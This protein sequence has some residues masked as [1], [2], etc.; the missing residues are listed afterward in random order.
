M[1]LEI[2]PHAGFC[3][4]VRRA[5]SA[6]EALAE[7]GEPACTLGE[8]IHNP[9]VV[10]MLR[11][12]GIPPV[13]D[14]GEAAGRRVL[15]RSHGVSPAVLQALE[16]AG[17]AVED[18]TCPFVDKLHH[19]AEEASAD[20]SPVIVVGERSHP[21]VAGTVGWIR[22][23]AWVV[24]TPEEAELLP[25]M[26]R[27]TVCSQTTFPP[28]VWDAV[29][30]VLRRK[31]EQLTEKCTICPATEIRQREAREL[32]ARSDAM[33]VVGGRHSANTA[34]LYATC[35]ALC[36]RTILVECAAEIPPAFANTHSE[37][38]GI[39]AGASTPDGLLKE[40]VT[41]MTDNE[42]MNPVAPQEAAE[43]DFAAAID[44]TMVHYRPGAVLTGTVISIG[45]EEVIVNIGGKSDGLIKKSDLVDK[46][47]QPGS[48]IE[49]EVVK[50]NDGEGNVV[51]SQ[52]NIVN[53]KAWEALM[54]KYNAGEYVT[55]VGREAVKGGL[56][57]DV[58]GIRAFVPASQLD[59]RYVEKIASFVGKEMKLKIIEVDEKKKRV[60]ASRRVAI[61][62]EA[63]A[64]KEEAWSRLEE[65]A[66]IHGIVR[67]LTAFGAFVD[68][69][70][71]DGLVHITDLSWAHI[72]DPSE[73]VKPNQEID[74][75]VLKL[76]RERDRIQLGYKQLQ[77]KPWDNAELKYPVG[78]IVAGKAVRITSFGCFVELEPG[79][80]GL[81]HI[82]QCAPTPVAKVE[83]AVTVGEIVHVKVLSVDTENKRISLSIRQALEEE[84]M[85]NLEEEN[86]EL[87]EGGEAPAE[88]APVEEAPAE[89][90]AP[91]APEA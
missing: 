85:D 67:R 12:K 21:E 86:L 42:N 78:S 82:T 64:R 27:A 20:G 41:T 4:G 19:I 59:N 66:V 53:R 52:R 91:E 46:D 88:E 57:A 58:D 77:P 61:Q 65:G 39:T 45:D 71:V 43:S 29:V 25:E 49:V 38:I 75:V 79:L 26:A 24:A 16:A 51:L 62:E 44:S 10:D 11:E 50:V 73:V 63:A 5:V 36:P 48:E 87:A 54:A 13:A 18:L 60:V 70:G 31:V 3:M 1:P 80:D 14:V 83:D 90:A 15:I 30:A 6:A 55:G 56:I 35:R 37:K 89:E 40:V 69:G 76:D 2:A 7:Q 8:L 23:R 32:A 9:Q 84:A 72:K 33:I 68:V 17:C 22:S 34:K 47:V 74:V 28:K 81:V